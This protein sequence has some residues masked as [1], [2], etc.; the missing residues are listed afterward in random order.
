MNRMTEPTRQPRPFDDPDT[1]EFAVEYD[2]TWIVDQ[3]SDNAEASESS[4]GR[5]RLDRSQ[6]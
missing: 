2:Q 1:D 6:A 3:S 4:Q 5:P